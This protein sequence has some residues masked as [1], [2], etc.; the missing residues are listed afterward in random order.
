M[1][2]LLGTN[3]L[4]AGG[5]GGLLVL[6]V[7]ASPLGSPLPLESV[8]LGVNN[9]GDAASRG[10]SGPGGDCGGEKDES[11]KSNRGQSDSLQTFF[12]MRWIHLELRRD[13]RSLISPH[14]TQVAEMAII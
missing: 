1:H 14:F 3:L 13:L 5:N 6:V 11:G 7:L 9:Q 10:G 8:L 4:D 12:M 2:Q